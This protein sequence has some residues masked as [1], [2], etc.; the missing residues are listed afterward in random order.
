MK[1]KVKSFDAKRGFGFIIPEDGGGDVF[2]HWSSILRDGFKTL[3]PGDKVE[4][5]I[6]ETTRGIQAKAVVIL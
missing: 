5:T 4:F 1:G 2:V 6:E 3:E